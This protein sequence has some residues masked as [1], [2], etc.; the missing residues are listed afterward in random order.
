MFV[1]KGRTCLCE[2]DIPVGLRDVGK[3]DAGGHMTGCGG[4]STCAV[5][6]GLFEGAHSLD[7]QLPPPP[8]FRTAEMKNWSEAIKIHRSNKHFQLP[9]SGQQS[10]HYM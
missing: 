4:W 8:P 5:G 1:Q 6:G 7:T 9:K 2:R 3:S 10:S